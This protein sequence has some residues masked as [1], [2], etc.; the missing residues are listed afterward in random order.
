[1]CVVDSIYRVLSGWI[2]LT[3][4]VLLFGAS[5]SHRYV[6]LLKAGDIPDASTHIDWEY[7]QELPQS[8]DLHLE[9]RIIGC[10]IHFMDTRDSMLNIDPSYGRAYAR[11]LIDAANRRLK[12]NAK[13]ALPIG[14]Q[15]PVWDAHIRLKLNANDVFFHYTDEVFYIKKGVRRNL[16]DRNMIRALAKSSDAYVNIFVMPYDPEEIKAGRQKMDKAGIALGTS[17][18]L[19]GV[20]DSGEPAWNYAGL[21]VH[22][23][24]HVLGLRH[25]WNINDGCEDTPRHPNCWSQTQ[26]APCDEPI[27]NNVMDYNPHQNALTPCQI[28]KIHTSIATPGTVQYGLAQDYWCNQKRGS[29][30]LI[31]SPRSWIKPRLVSGDIRIKEGGKLYIST[32]VSMAAQT[33]IVVDKGG[34]LILDGARLYNSCQSPWNGILMHTEGSVVTRGETTLQNLSEVLDD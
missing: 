25:T 14:N 13:M 17:I 32:W 6:S 12:Q 16:Y 21:L 4:I 5:C 27:S 22:E 24:C 31:D 23:L 20:I 11:A 10:K 18:K 15:T 30:L 7:W 8:D 26:T 3:G 19:A 28:Q 33:R 2:A 34:L 1:M 29:V 9:D